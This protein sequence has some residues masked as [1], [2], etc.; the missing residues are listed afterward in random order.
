MPEFTDSLESTFYK[1]Y[2]ENF[3]SIRKY[4]YIILKNECVADDIAQEVFIKVWEHQDWLK[5]KCKLKNFAYATVRNLSLNL[6][7]HKAIEREYAEELLLRMKNKNIVLS[8]RISSNLYYE[9]LL[10]TINI[11]LMKLPE[12]RRQIFLL[13]RKY[14]M[15]NREIADTLNI[16]VRTVEHQIY[17][18]LS[19]LKTIVS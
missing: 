8:E 18:T 15:S 12:R 10:E 5:D 17:L 6:L 14:K 7:K 4:A 3:N 19:F 1:F 11:S 13:S 9:E 2:K 16:S